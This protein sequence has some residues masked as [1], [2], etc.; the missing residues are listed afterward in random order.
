MKIGKKAIHMAIT[1]ILAGSL[2]IAGCGKETT[3]SVPPKGEPPQVG[4]VKIVPRNVSITTELAGRT[5]SYLIAEV[6]PQVGGI[7]QK[8]LFTEGS[9]V[10]AG[11]VLYQIDPATYQ[12]AF[13]SARAAMDKAQANVMPAQLKA[14]RYKE[15]VGI[16]A[17]SQQDYDNAYAALKQAQAD[18]AVSKAAVETARI[19]LDYTHVTAPISGRIGKSSVTIGA[20]VTANQSASLATIQKLDPVYVDV[21]QSNVE[22]LRL[23][24]DLADGKIRRDVAS[25]AKV[26]LI[27]EDGALYPLDGTLKFSDVTVDQNTG[28][29]TLRMVFPNPKHTL[30]PGMFVRAILEE[31]V[32]DGAILAPERGVS[33]DPAGNAV[34]M[35]VGAD[36]K[37]ESRI[38]KVSRT[39]GDNWLVTE[40]LNSGDRLILEGTQKAPVGTLVKP[41]FMD[42]KTS[43]ATAS[44]DGRTAAVQE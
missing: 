24:R 9:N 21:T 3:A 18:V 1:G 13:D 43:A 15:L 26:K 7:V 11:Q 8:R 20:L 30:L 28:S 32:V 35:V 29:V 6:R 38:L 14:E 4:V 33:R 44:I 19:Q 27:L 2:M 40:G 23:K 17:V 22:A 41:V 12:A 16:R 36:N 25:Q 5:S 10:R 42:D 34:A 39:I 37:V 31:G